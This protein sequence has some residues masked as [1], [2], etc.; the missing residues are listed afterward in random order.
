M[1]KLRRCIIGIAIIL[2]INSAGLAKDMSYAKKRVNPFTFTPQAEVIFKKNDFVVIPS[3]EF[4]D[5]TSVYEDCKT[6]GIPIFV[7]ND[8]ILHTTHILLDY[9]WRIV[10]I[11]KIRP[12]LIELTQA[13]LE[14]SLHQYK[15]VKYPNVKEAALKNVMFFSVA[16]KLLDRSKPIPDLVKSKVRN[17]IELID[18]HKGW[19]SS[20][21]FEDPQ[22]KY[23]YQEDYSQYIPRGHYTR[24][25]EFESFFRTLM[26]YGR[27][28]FPLPRKGWEI[29]DFLTRTTRQ[30]L[31][32]TYLLTQSQIKDKQAFKIWEDIHQSIT[33]FIG[34][35]D[36]LTFYDYRALLEKV[37]GR[38]PSLKD[39]ESDDSIIT[40]ILEA[41]KLKEPKIESGIKWTTM[42]R[43]DAFYKKGFKFLGQ[44][45]TPDSYIFQQ[46]VY[47]R[48]QGRFLP[49]GL[50]VMAVFSSKIAKSILKEESDFKKEGY[51]EKLKEL[52]GKFSWLS[53]KEWTKSL[54]WM[55]LYCLQ[56]LLEEKRGIY[57][58]F[59]T[60]QNWVK[61][62]LNTSLSS[63]TELRHDTILYVKQPYTPPKGGLLRLTKGYVEPYPL[64]YR[65]VR[66]LIQSTKDNLLSR[67][68][69]IPECEKKL[70]DFE[71]LL[72][73]LEAISQK[74]LEG[75]PLNPQEYQLIWNIGSTL[76]SLTHFSKPI[77]DK[78][79]SGTDSKMMV[80]SDVHTDANTARVLEEAVGYPFIIYVMVP[81]EGKL[82]LTRG[83]VFSYY[84]FPQP[85]DKRLTDEEWQKILE[86][87]KE[88]ALP[89]WTEGF[90]VKDNSNVEFELDDVR[91]NF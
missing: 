8:A 57:P 38:S 25:K 84:E 53:E 66:K 86:M 52:E 60:N 11:E 48:V 34:E 73:Q 1:K 89:E 83:A 51:R 20:P 72:S 22:S 13:L 49:K 15:E 32:I 58:Q 3:R 74:E 88:P 16:L 18:K 67:D 63:W 55:W 30:A 2:M 54:Y 7:T 62:S 40:F 42:P 21:I 27:M 80:I 17:E 75:K 10:E 50:D 82:T 87:G 90:M 79:T 4:K 91:V 37:Y 78:I 77:M 36:D 47:P 5:V 46:L 24:N 26:W 65:R 45:Y 29:D 28:L 31:L 9:T 12:T 19:A 68:L 64:V 70:E 41:M 43:P 59:M 44:R 39:F 85:I 81:I 33:F 6:K 23:L 61:K 56:P 14:E 76:S 69:L 35:S 71:K